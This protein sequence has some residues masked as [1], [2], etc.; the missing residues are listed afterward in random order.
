MT[1]TACKIRST[2]LASP[3]N[4]P[5]V[6]NEGGAAT[7]QALLR[8]AGRVMGLGLWSETG[9]LSQFHYSEEAPGDAR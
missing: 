4:F 3:A 9:I 6:W 5:S 8:C 2:R 1:G 7:G